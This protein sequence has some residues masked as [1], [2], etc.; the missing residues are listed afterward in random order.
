MD[1]SLSNIDWTLTVVK[2]VMGFLGILVYAT[3][4]VR[5]HLHHFNFRILLSEN[6]TFWS[7][8]IIMIT[9][10]L[11]ILTISPDTG[12]ALKTMVGLDVNNE[13]S[14]F[15]LLGWSL[16]SLSNSMSKKKLNKDNNNGN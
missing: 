7:W 14:G 11:L 8:S 4:K 13:P 15:L 1:Y 16:S 5:E 3:W 2:L 10:V 12:V 6:R 9:L